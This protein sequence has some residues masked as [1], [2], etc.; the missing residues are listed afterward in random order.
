MSLS[1][2]GSKHHQWN[3]PLS[4]ETKEKISKKLTECLN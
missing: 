2:M 3:K 4:F 1:Q